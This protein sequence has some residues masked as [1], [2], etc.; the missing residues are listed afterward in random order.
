MTHRSNII[1][2]LSLSARDGGAVHDKRHNKRRT[3]F[4]Y[5]FS[6]ARNTMGEV[7]TMNQEHRPEIQ[8]PVPPKKLEVDPPIPAKIYPVIDNDLARDNV[9]NDL[10]AADK[11]EL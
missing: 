4:A 2:R 6:P 11:N 1:S 3:L 8:H 9:E 5:V 10:P 7:I